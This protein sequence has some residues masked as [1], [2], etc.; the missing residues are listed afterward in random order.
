MS[1]KSPHARTPMMNGRAALLVALNVHND[2][3]VALN[4]HNDVSARHA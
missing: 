3:L 1:G 2:L 4:M